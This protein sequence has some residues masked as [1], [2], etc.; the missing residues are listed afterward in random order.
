[1]LRKIVDFFVE[2]IS[3]REQMQTKTLFNLLINSD[4]N[5][6]KDNFSRYACIVRLQ[7]L[8]CYVNTRL[9]RIIERFCLKGPGLSVVFDSRILL[10]HKR[11]RLIL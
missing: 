7:V 8:I 10:R 1:M 5:Y 6:K 11:R 9:L 2:K 3:N 4:A